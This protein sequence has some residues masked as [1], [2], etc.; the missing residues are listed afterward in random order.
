MGLL[1]DRATRALQGRLAAQRAVVARSGD[2][3]P[4]LLRA[5]TAAARAELTRSGAGLD[6]LDPFA[7]L[8]RGYAIVRAPDGRVVTDA[9]Q[10]TVG[11]TLEVRLAQGGLDV[12]V[13]TVRDSDA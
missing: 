11:D 8:E 5:G 3:L 12:S 1:L 7:T 10:Q 4:S 2:R 6:A 13:D 9:A